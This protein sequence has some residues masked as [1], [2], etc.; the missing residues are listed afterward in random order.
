MTTKDIKN[1]MNSTCEEFRKITGI[2]L[3]KGKLAPTNEDLKHFEDTMYTTSEVYTK[4]GERAG[5]LYDKLK[6][7][8]EELGAAND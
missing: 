7:L 6:R 4:F 2:F 5:K 8:S 1:K 3:N